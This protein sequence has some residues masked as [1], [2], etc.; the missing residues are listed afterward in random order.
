[1]PV[2]KVNL[3][4]AKPMKS[5]NAQLSQHGHTLPERRNVGHGIGKKLVAIMAMFLVIGFLVWSIG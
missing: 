1:M 5:R 4:G 3:H 2:F